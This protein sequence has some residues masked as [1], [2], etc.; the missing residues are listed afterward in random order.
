MNSLKYLLSAN[1]TQRLKSLNTVENSAVVCEVISWNIAT[2]TFTG[3]A[4]DGSLRY[5]RFIGNASLPLGSQVS[6]VTPDGSLIGWADTK[7]R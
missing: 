1:Q 5:F 4:P 6:V 7:A 2:G 3:K